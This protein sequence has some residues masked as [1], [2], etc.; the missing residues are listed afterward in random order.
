MAQIP[1]GRLVKGKYKPICRDCAMYFS[2]TVIF[3]TNPAIHCGFSC[4]FFLVEML[5]AQLMADGL[6][7]AL[8]VTPHYLPTLKCKTSMFGSKK[9]SKGLRNQCLGQ[10]KLEKRNPPQILS[11]N[12]LVVGETFEEHEKKIA[13]ETIS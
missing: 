6:Q 10:V 1:N 13:A 3:F 4:L 12:T 8:P 7:G 9:T 11:N 2:I 5:I